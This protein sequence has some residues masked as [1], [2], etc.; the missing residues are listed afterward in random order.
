MRYYTAPELRSPNFRY[1]VMQG[2]HWPTRIASRVTLEEAERIAADRGV[3]IMWNCSHRIGV[4]TV[5]ITL[6]DRHS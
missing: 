6:S 4:T 3:S 5:E 1:D 2:I